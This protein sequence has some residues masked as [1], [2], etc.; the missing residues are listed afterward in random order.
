MYTIWGNPHCKKC[1][2]I[3][4]LLDDKQIPYKEETL[5]EDSLYPLW[6]EGFRDLV[7]DIYCMLQWQERELPVITRDDK[8]V[9]WQELSLA[10]AEK[11]V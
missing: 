9:T 10:L 5:T 2:E 4:Q 7:T 1:K 8:A 3:K 6:R 11:V